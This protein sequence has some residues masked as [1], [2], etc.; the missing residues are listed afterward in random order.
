MPAEDDNR[1]ELAELRERIVKLE[2]KME[3]LTKRVDS[4][5]NYTR[6]LYNYLQK[7]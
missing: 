1:K 3:E 5:Q 2:V 6:E 4:I 7:R